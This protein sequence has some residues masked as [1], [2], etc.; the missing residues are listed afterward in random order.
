M[1][2]TA[3]T[4]RL[5][6]ALTIGPIPG[7]DDDLSDGLLRE[8]WT[9]HRARLLASHPADSQPWAFWAF[10]PSVP[11]S[12]RGQ[13]PRLVEVD[14]DDDRAAEDPD[15]DFRRAAWLAETNGARSATNA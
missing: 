5:C 12:L 14:V 15:L 10:E 13:R 4:P 7:R 2:R 11:D 8:V 9:E 1:P 3:L 6:L